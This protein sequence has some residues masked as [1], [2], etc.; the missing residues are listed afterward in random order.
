MFKFI[1]ADIKKF[2]IFH[3]IYTASN[4]FDRFDWNDRV[5]D[6]V[7]C[8]TNT[9][10]Y[11]VHDN[12]KRIGGFVLKENHLNYPFIVAPFYDRNLFWGK[13]LEYTVQ[14]S[15][16][17]EVFLNE[18]AEADVE[19]LVKSYGAVIQESK[20]RMIRPTEQCTYL[21]NDDFYFDSLTEADKKEIINVIYEAHAHNH[22]ST[23]LKPD[24]TEI[25]TAVERRFVSFS[26]TN[27][28]YMGNIVKSKAT[29][30]IVGVCIAGIYPSS[31]IYSTSNFATI[32]QVSV[33]P[34]YQR[35]GIAKAM[36][37][38]SINDAKSASP[39]MTLGVSQ[40]N[41]AKYLYSEV[42]FRAG[43]SYSELHYKCP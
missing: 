35:K 38:K 18:I 26:Q 23:I 6:A 42:G 37:L 20:K 16:N 17:K 25:E 19:V 3:T 28:L 12:Q 32:H 8:I 36:I 2:A 22:A 24:I 7:D 27:T 9:D 43:D 13:V 5:D 15:E 39:A 33:R 40:D 4:I 34:L 1:K 14:T 10:V 31:S 41:P 30:K 29:N 21:L 11:F